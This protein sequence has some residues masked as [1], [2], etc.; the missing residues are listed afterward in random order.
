SFQQ[1]KQTSNNGQAQSGDRRA[2]VGAIV[3]GRRTIRDRDGIR[4]PLVRARRDRDDRDHRD[5]RRDHRRARFD[6]HR[7]I[8]TLPLGYSWY[9]YGYS[10]TGGYA[11]ETPTVII[12]ENPP[13]AAVR[14]NG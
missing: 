4:N 12:V 1:P 13:G 8:N 3:G 7:H 11:Y 14:T 9:G 10:T 5:D 2:F 6:H